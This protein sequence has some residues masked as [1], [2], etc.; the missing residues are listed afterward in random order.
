M[1]DT[2]SRV[3]GFAF[4][5]PDSGEECWTAVRAGQGQ[6]ILA[7]SRKTD[8]DIELAFPKPEAERLLAM[9]AQAIATC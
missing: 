6:V 5:E 1:N 4:Q 9:L 2:F 3:G 8:S 7:L